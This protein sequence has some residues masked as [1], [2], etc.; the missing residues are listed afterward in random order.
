[1]LVGKLLLARL[2]LAAA[3]ALS[4]PLNLLVS[5]AGPQLSD[6]QQ[7][8]AALAEQH[9]LGCVQAVREL[10]PRAGG[11]PKDAAPWAVQ[12]SVGLTLLARAMQTHLKS[13]EPGP[14]HPGAAVLRSLQGASQQIEACLEDA[15]D[16]RAALGAASAVLAWRARDILG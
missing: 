4:A 16:T 15:A 2:E 9:V 10:E 7:T 1:M 8:M 14:C 12:A 5:R 11:K 13:G 3:S 6:R